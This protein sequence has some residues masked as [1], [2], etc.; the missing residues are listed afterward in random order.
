MRATEDRGRESSPPGIESDLDR[1][2][3]TLLLWPWGCLTLGLVP[4]VLATPGPTGA[5]QNDP[6]RPRVSHKG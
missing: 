6:Q 2:V 5:R 4:H 1:V 3:G